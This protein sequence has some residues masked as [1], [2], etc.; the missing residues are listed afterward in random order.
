MNQPITTSPVP[1]LGAGPKPVRRSR[2]VWTCAALA[3]VVP[4]AVA[5]FTVRGE[6]A[7]PVTRFEIPAPEL[8]HSTQT[9]TLF[10][11]LAMMV[12]AAWQVSVGDL[13]PRALAVR[14]AVVALFAGVIGEVSAFSAWGVGRLV[15]PDLDLAIDSADEWQDVAG[16]GLVYLLG[17]VFGIAVGALVRDTIIAA[18][19]VVFVPLVLEPMSILASHSTEG[20]LPFLAARNFLVP[21]WTR[22]PGGAWG[23][24]T[25][26]AAC[27]LGLLAVAFVVQWRRNARHRLNAQLT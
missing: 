8:V 9:A 15:A 20:L 2:S 19:I 3:V 27:C 26:F 16:T 13:T 14:T 22:F 4:S 10:G 1:P 12:M 25:Y 21:N 18:T 17:A 24:L 5:A 7:Y 11:L 23:S 6:Y